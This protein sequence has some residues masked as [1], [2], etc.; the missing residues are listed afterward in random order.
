MTKLEK[1]GKVEKILIVD[2]LDLLVI[3]IRGAC[4][5]LIVKRVLMLRYQWV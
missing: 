4:G 3:S 1:K 5:V 2:L